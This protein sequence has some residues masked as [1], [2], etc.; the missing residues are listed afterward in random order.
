MDTPTEGRIVHY[1]L[2]PYRTL[3]GTSPSDS[4]S[5]HRAAIVTRAF[6]GSPDNKV[7]LT[8]FPDG[9][10]DGYS[11]GQLL[12]KGSVPQDEDGREFGTWHYPERVS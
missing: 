2:A 4:E 10:N 5:C 12:W 7:N 1:V 6:P 3:P 8:V 11:A 9:Q